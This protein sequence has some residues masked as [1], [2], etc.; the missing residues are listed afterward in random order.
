MSTK[1]GGWIIGIAA[2]VIIAFALLSRAMPSV[3]QPEYSMNQSATP[4]EETIIKIGAVLPLSGDGASYGL[5]E[6]KALQLAVEE[7]NANGGVGGKNIEVYFEDGKCEGKEATAAISKLISIDKVSFVFGGACSSETLAMAPIAEAAKVI[8][9]SPSSTNP[10][11]TNAG[12]YIFRTAPSDA[13]AGK[14]A[15]L[16][17][18]NTMKAKKVAIIS[19]Q[20]DYAQGLRNVFKLFFTQN[21]G[22]VVADE[23]YASVDTDFRTQITKIKAS[24]ADVLYVVPQ[25]PATG[26]LIAKQLQQAGVRTPLLTAEVLLGRD[27]VKQNAKELEGM[28][29]VEQYFNPIAPLTA[30]FIAAYKTRFNEDLSFPTY[31]ANMYSQAYLLREAI[32][33]VGAS[34]D[35][36]KG[37]LYQVKNWE[38]ALGSLT[39]DSNGDPIT[40][41][42]IERVKAGALEKIEVFKPQS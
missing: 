33:Q 25:T 7:I 10:D 14:I 39:L 15:A 35:A 40:D 16:Y 20:K 28:I 17:A 29:G 36:V 13:L 26:I 2:V 6:Q 41:Y 21:G 22:E 5:P 37:Y 32:N 38:H 30:K 3:E 23:V 19:E 42:V 1:V 18:V 34:V 4:V 31:Q 8:V 11:I 27:V 12:D 9:I 24:K